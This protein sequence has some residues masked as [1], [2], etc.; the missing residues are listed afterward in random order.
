MRILMLTDFYPPIIGGVERHVQALSRALVRRG[1]DVAVATL[2][3]AGQAPFAI[4]QG[5][6]VYRIQGLTQRVRFLYQSQEK[7]YHPPC[8]DPGIMLKLQSIMQRECPHVI[9]GHGWMLYSYLPLKRAYGIP[10]VATLHD[11]GLICAKRDLLQPSLRICSGPGL[12]RC[13][14]CCMASYGTAK[15]AIA[16]ASQRLGTNWLYGVDRFL[17]VSQFVADQHRAKIGSALSETT[18]FFEHEAPLRIVPNF[19]DPPQED[20]QPL[21]SRQMASLLPRRDGFLLFVGALAHHKGISVL[22][23]AYVALRADRRNR[24]VHS[25]QRGSEAAGTVPAGDIPELVI[26]GAGESGDAY[27]VQEGITIIRDAPPELVLH[28]WQR[29][30]VGIVPSLWPDPCP[31]VAL[32][33]MYYRRPLIASRVGGLPDI[34]ADGETGLLVPPGDPPALQRAL[35]TLL[36]HPDDAARMGQAGYQRLHRL[37]TLDVVLPQIEEIYHEVV[38]ASLTVAR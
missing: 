4:D 20:Q 14:R 6:R 2:W 12:T 15:G 33:A 16:W 28:A 30:S 35:A 3:H 29:C 31:T 13:L 26:I 17:A 27:R 34:V 7:R 10:V 23:D 25:S 9:H 36:D 8:P 38:G 21:L 32:E 22:L 11:Y 1:H 19:F 24:S 18:G 37:F 5:V